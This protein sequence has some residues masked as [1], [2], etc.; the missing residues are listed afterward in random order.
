MK[1]QNYLRQSPVFVVDKTASSL[2]ARLAERLAPEEVVPMQ[3][4]VLTALYFESGQPALPSALA[5]AFETSRSS[6][7]QCLTALEKRKLIRRELHPKDSRSYRISLTTD[8]K[9]KA[10]R[11]VRIFDHFQQQFESKIGEASL[12]GAM[13]M[14][15][16]LTA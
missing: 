8:G 2:N 1:I 3:G 11:L 5:K 9:K 12:M 15:R 14:L 7:S 10:I 13:K 6:M 4:L 16:S